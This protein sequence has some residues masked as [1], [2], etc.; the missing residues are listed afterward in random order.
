MG[1]VYIIG[2]FKKHC[3]WR[4]SHRQTVLR[5][6]VQTFQIVQQ[7]DNIAF[8]RQIISTYNF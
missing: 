4:N 1:F 5:E 3:S 8:L 6:G 2:L 7:V